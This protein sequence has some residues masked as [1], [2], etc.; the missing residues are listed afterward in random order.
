MAGTAIASADLFGI[1][2]ILDIFDHKDQKK[3]KHHDRGATVS[4]QQNGG[5]NKASRPN[6]RGGSV[7]G[8]RGSGFG[9]RPHRGPGGHDRPG[10]RHDHPRGQASSSDDDQTGTANRSSTSGD[11]AESAIPGARITPP[12]VVAGSGGNGV[13]R[14]PASGS[15]GRA[16]NLAPVP[17]APS[18]RSVVIR[19]DPP[20]APAPSAPV[21]RVVAPPVVVPPVPVVPI[22]VPPPVAAPSA[23]GGAPAAP[24]APA[25]TPPPPNAPAPAAPPPD[26]IPDSFRI[27]YADYLRTA[28]T[29]DLLFAVLPGMAGLVLLTAAGGAIGLRQ[30]RA[31]QALPAPQ[32]ARFMA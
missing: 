27:G 17:T 25:L 10:G 14:V 22:V 5:S 12:A 15:A 2:G 29:V 19:A 31:A 6:D 21:A 16:P 8:Q 20:A 13:S 23:G 18:S 9:P 3:K 24:A 4:G 30:A 7:G 11:V 28:N 1:G 26:A 32:I